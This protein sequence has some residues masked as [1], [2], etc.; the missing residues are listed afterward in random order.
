M[1]VVECWLYCNFVQEKELCTIWDCESNGYSS[2]RSHTGL[3]IGLP[4]TACIRLTCQAWPV[5]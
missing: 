3:D 5:R 1:C 2:G 4:D